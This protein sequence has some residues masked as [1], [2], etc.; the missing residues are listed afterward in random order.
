MQAGGEKS[1]NFLQ[2]KISS[3]NNYGIYCAPPLSIL[4][5]GTVYYQL[6]LAYGNLYCIDEN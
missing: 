2:A 5:M 4:D 6:R 1:E 3:Y